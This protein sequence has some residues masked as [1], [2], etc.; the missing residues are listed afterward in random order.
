MLPKRR[1]RPNL[2]PPLLLRER[3]RDRPLEGTAVDRMTAAT[4]RVTVV[5][6]PLERPL[7]CLLALRSVLCS[8][9]VSRRRGL[10]AQ[11]EEG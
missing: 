2:L 7:A 3:S 1:R 5:A 10:A 9:P 4:D 8:V 6:C 11:P